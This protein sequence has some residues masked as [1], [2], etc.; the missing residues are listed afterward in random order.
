MNRAELLNEL[1]KI[2]KIAD[3]GLEDYIDGL[4]DF[5]YSNF[6]EISKK[7]EMLKQKLLEE[8]NK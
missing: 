8:Q 5:T 6:S 4:E 3:T 7:I 1:S 2:Q